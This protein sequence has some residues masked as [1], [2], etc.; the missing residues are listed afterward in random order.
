MS[1]LALAKSLE[2]QADMQ[3]WTLTAFQ[4]MPLDKPHAFTTLH[5][6]TK[7]FAVCWYEPGKTRT[8]SAEHLILPV[9]WYSHVVHAVQKR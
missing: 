6:K 1:S 2:V 9:S 8:A 5:N 4:K 7:I 3:G